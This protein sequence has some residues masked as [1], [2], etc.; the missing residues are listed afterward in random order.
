MWASMARCVG[1]ETD[2]SYDLEQLTARVKTRPGW[3][4][5]ADTSWNWVAVKLR[6][7]ALPPS[8]ASSERPP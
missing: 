7:A 4:T 5:I 3:A 1:L 6:L 8:P 2:A